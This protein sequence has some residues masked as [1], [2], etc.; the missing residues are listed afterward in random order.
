MLP[1]EMSRDMFG[2]SGGMKL[3][4]K[5]VFIS[6]KMEILP[7]WLSFVRAVVDSDDLELNVSREILQE[8]KVL[9]VIRKK[10][11]RKR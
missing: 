10:L 11:V 1:Y 5:R 7:R 9:R 8:G 4:I 6:D 3:Y 2:D